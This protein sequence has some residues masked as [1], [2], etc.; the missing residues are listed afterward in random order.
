MPE[1]QEILLVR[2]G[3]STANAKG[4][5]QGQMEFPLSERGRVQ[6]GLAGRSLSGQPFEGLYSSPLSRAF[7]TAEIIR[8][9][10]GVA[11][12]VVACDGLIERRGGILEGHTWVE[13]EQQNPELAKKFLAIPEEERWELV[14]AETD[15]EVIARFE[16]ALSSIRALHPDGARIVVVSHGGVMRAFLM[17]RFGP[18]ILPG[19]Q[20]AANAS[21]TRLQWGATGPRLLE[22]AS[23]AHLTEDPG[24]STVE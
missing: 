7:E 23:T 17:K 1:L 12:D 9:R 16:E 13:Q 24:P 8:D 18:E 4:I 6:A 10:T 5:W 15:E 21:I 11:R 22:V 3:Q 14:G 20:R 2:H 19:A